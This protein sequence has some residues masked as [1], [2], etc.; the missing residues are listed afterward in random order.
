MEHADYV[1][2]LNRRVYAFG[3]PHEVLEESLL[4]KTYGRSVVVV[5]L[6]GG[7]LIFGGDK[8]A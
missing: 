8:H 1:L 7:K 6:E 4:E 3:K 5:H 2:L